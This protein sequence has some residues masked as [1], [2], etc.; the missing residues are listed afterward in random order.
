MTG[1][2]G[3]RGF[4]AVAADRQAVDG[5]H[6]D[7]RGRGQ[8]VRNRLSSIMMLRLYRL[9]A[10][11][12]SSM[13]AATSIGRLAPDAEITVLKPVSPDHQVADTGLLVPK[14]PS[15]SNRIAVPGVW[16]TLSSISNLATRTEQDA[17]GA[18]AANDTMMDMSLGIAGQARDDI[19][20]PPVRPATV[21]SIRH[22]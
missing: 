6:L 17:A 18:V 14:R 7:Q 12:L 16:N 2:I 9:A 15:P 19:A 5:I 8:N 21:S 1:R 11:K 20:E 4:D 22:G 3:R 10:R 13:P